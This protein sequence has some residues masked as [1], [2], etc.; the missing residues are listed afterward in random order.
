MYLTEAFSQPLLF[1]PNTHPLGAEGIAK[2]EVITRGNTCVNQD[3]IVI[4]GNLYV[5]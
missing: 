3:C 1:I 5:I 2:E 4:S